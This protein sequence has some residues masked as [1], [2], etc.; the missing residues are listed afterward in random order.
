MARSPLSPILSA[1]CPALRTLFTCLWGCSPC[2][3]VSVLL[4]LFPLPPGIP[5]HLPK[6]IDL[7]PSV[8][9][10]L[11]IPTATTEGTG[12]VAPKPCGGGH[13]VMLLGASRGLPNLSVLS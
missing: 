2:K 7:R 5:S 12:L 10:N 13:Q 4:A 9:W 3:M 11:I 8:C 6:D 1:P